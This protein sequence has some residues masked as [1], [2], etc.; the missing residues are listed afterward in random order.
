MS[1]PLKAIEEFFTAVFEPMSPG[2]GRELHYYDGYAHWNVLYDDKDLL[3]ITADKEI[4]PSAL[5]LVELGVYCSRVSKSDAL[6][7]W[8]F[9]ILHP[10]DTEQTERYVVLTKTKEGRVSLSTS[11]GSNPEATKPS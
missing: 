10:N 7:I 1:L 2:P 4:G 9:L 11:V 5:P 6:A 3:F 8:P